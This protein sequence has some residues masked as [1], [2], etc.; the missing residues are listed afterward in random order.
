MMMMFRAYCNAL[1]NYFDQIA[2]D[3][4]VAFGIRDTMIALELGAVQTLLVWDEL[5]IERTVSLAQS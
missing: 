2:K 4:N 1:Q 3:G 5:K